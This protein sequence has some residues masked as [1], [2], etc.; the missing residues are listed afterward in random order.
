[1]ADLTSSALQQC[2]DGLTLPDGA[3]VWMYTANRVLS[4][5]E[6]ESVQ[7]ALTAFR[8]SWAAHG[9]P[10]R[11]ESAILLNQ[12]VVL[13]VD[14][15]PQI[16]TGCS[17]D[18]SVAALRSLNEAAPTLADLDVLDRS[19]VVYKEGKDAPEWKRARL[20]DFWAMRKA[21]TLTDEAQILDSTVT[22]LGALRKE[23]VKRLADS[24]HAH[25]W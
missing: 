4:D 16:A 12:V 2:F 20:H 3:R 6:C 13:A 25:M 22:N 9:S 15:E 7:A 10:L 11:S 24:W 23:G 17:I 8:G 1:M 21:G 5:K 18:A 14:E 19:W